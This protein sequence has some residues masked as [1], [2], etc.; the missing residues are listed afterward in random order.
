MVWALLLGSYQI[1]WFWA[2]KYTPIMGPTDITELDVF[3]K[4]YEEFLCLGHQ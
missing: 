3:L 2:M 1:D 4:R